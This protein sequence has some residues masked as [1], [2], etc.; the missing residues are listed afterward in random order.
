M[1][2]EEDDEE[3]ENDDEDEDEGMVTFL[4]RRGKEEWL[5]PTVE[6]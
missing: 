1:S 4:M 2:E 3:D 6:A 5:N